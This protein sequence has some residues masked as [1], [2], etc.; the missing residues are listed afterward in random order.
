MYILN[1]TVKLYSNK[2]V[3]KLPRESNEIPNEIPWYGNEI[4]MKSC[5]YNNEI[6]NEN[7]QVQQ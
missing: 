6:P 2:I 4:T 1:L 3:M 5:R 7:A